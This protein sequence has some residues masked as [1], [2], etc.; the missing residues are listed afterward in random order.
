[1]LTT[2]GLRRA[3]ERRRHERRS[4]ARG[5]GDRRRHDRRRRRLRSLMFAA[6]AFA[7]PQQLKSS[8]ALP[9]LNRWQQAGPRVSVSIDSFLSVA[10]EPPN[11]ELTEEAASGHRVDPAPIPSMTTIQPAI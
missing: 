3:A 7:F 6:L 10:T 5:D 4:C 9:L 11:D 1:M 8:R 2:R